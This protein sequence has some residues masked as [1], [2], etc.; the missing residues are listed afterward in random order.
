MAKPT[1]VQSGACW[2]SEGCQRLA[3]SVKYEQECSALLCMSDSAQP[4]ALPQTVFSIFAHA[5][6]SA[7][8]QLR[9]L[10]F[11]LSFVSSRGLGVSF[12]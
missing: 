1:L 5:Q 8:Q 3:K 10:T 12:V 7:L 11:D 6:A 4:A 9:N 2:P